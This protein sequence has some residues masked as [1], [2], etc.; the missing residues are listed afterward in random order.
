VKVISLRR[1]NGQTLSPKDNPV[2]QGLDTL[3]ISGL[4]ESIALVETKLSK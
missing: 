1:T 2:L 3:V 4:P